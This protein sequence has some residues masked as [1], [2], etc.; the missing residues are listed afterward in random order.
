MPRLTYLDD[1]PEFGHS[2]QWRGRLRHCPGSPA[3]LPR[4]RGRGP[5]GLPGGVRAPGCSGPGPAPGSLAP[6]HHRPPVHRPAAATSGQ[7]GSGHGRGEV[8]PDAQKA[9]R[10]RGG[11]T[12]SPPGRPLSAIP[13]PSQTTRAAMRAAR[14][15]TRRSA[16]R[17]TGRTQ[18][19]LAHRGCLT[20]PFSRPIRR[21]A[22]SPDFRQPQ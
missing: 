9:G 11:R 13:L 10:S 15:A 14:Y 20:N 18:D 5:A 2:R 19:L 16:R 3:Q 7:C 21:R 1:I 4:G 6:L 8:C 17:R 12:H 22:Q